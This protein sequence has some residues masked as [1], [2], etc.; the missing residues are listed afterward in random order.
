MTTAERVLTLCVGISAY[1]Q[2]MLAPGEKALEY[3]ALS[4]AELSE[5]FRSAWT[6]DNS[7]HLRAVDGEGTLS[8]VRGLL[9]TETG[10]YDLFILYIGGHGQLQDGNFQFLFS[11]D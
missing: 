3:L 10:T 9:E 1:D 7:R 8:N 6:S 11:A 5:V 4:A 2:R